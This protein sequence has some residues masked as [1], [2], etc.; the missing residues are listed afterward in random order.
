MNLGSIEIKDETA[1]NIIIGTFLLAVFLLGVSVGYTT[2]RANSE[3]KQMCLYM[4]ALNDETLVVY[5]FPQC[6]EYF[7]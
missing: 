1:R 6:K 7:D 5:E 4:N 2:A 3:E